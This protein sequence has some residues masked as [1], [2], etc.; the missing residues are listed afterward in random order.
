MSVGLWRLILCSD[1]LPW[2]SIKADTLSS[3][4]PAK[5][6]WQAREFMSDACS[7]TNTHQHDICTGT[8]VTVQAKNV[9][10]GGQRG[11]LTHSHTHLV[12]HTQ[13][14]MSVVWEFKA[15]PEHHSI[16]RIWGSETSPFA[17]C[18]APL[19]NT[20]QQWTALLCVQQKQYRDLSTLLIYV[21]TSWQTAKIW[22]SLS[23]SQVLKLVLY[24]FCNNCIWM[25]AIFATEIIIQ[26]QSVHERLRIF[27]KWYVQ[28]GIYLPGT[29]PPVQ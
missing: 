9:R 20:E 2:P 12:M 10:K 17:D 8:D 25:I 4:G 1:L 26:P 21:M 23:A 16:A 5:G 28:Y 18:Q 14:Q 13:S 11:V 15:R 29:I 3:T 6:H 24:K 27:S 19:A 22:A 7:H